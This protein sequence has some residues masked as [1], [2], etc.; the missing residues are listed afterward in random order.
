[1]S[2]PMTTADSQRTQI[3][4]AREIKNFM[5]YHHRTFGNKLAALPP[6]LVSLEEKQESS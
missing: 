1:M 5:N 4:T 2:N 3:N 6:I